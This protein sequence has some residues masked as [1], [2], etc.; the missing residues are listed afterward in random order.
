[1]YVTFLLYSF[2]TFSLLCFTNVLQCFTI[3][4]VRLGLLYSGELQGLLF[5]M[6]FVCNFLSLLLDDL[7]LDYLPIFGFPDGLVFMFIFVVSVSW[8]YGRETAL[9]VFIFTFNF[10]LG[11]YIGRCIS[12]MDLWA[13]TSRG[14]TDM[15]SEWKFACVYMVA[16]L[17][18]EFWKEEML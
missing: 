12:H 1:M 16:V 6:L 11:E 7:L 2:W 13:L 3:S 5:G 9:T 8:W 15:I 18:L 17:T 10:L 4:L 14:F